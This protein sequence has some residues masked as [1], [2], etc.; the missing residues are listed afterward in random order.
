MPRNKLRSAK[1]DALNEANDDARCGAG[2]LDLSSFGVIK[3]FSYRNCTL[4]IPIIHSISKYHSM[5]L[6][7]ESENRGN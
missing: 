7:S 2:T 4:Y 3:R 5:I 6:V 1:E